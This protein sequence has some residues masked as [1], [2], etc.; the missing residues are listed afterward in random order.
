M[1]CD[2][3][4]PPPPNLTCEENFVASNN[5]ENGIFLGGDTNQ[6]LAADGIVGDEGFTVFGMDLNIF[7]DGHTDVEFYF[8]VYEDDGGLRGA[9]FDNNG[10]RNV[11][12]DD[13]IGHPVGSA[14]SNYGAQFA[15]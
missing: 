6:R 1:T 2:D 3:L 15:T 13:C 4:P 11:H 14:V 12:S 8:T 9:V 7:T 10:F 5:L